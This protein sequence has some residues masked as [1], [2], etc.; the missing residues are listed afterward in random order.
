MDRREKLDADSE[1]ASE[2]DTDS[3]GDNEGGVPPK[4]VTASCETVVATG[5]CSM[6]GT[7]ENAASRDGDN[8]GVKLSSGVVECN[9]K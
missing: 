2:S 8:V 7:E 6:G 5:Q 1:G 9:R 4:L 3:T